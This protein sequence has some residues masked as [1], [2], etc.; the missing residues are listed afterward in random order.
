MSDELYTVDRVADRLQL[1]PKTVLRF[2]REGR[3]R[4][5]RVGKGYRILRSDLEA[6]AGVAVDSTT[7]PLRARVTS[8]V[9]L[10]EVPAELSRR[11]STALQAALMTRPDRSN[12]IQLDTAYDSEARHLKVVI[13]A[14][15]ADA[16]AL[17]RTLEVFL[18]AFK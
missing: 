4:A 7:P 5:T 2:I 3:L 9:D 10:P 16:A 14:A 13:V 8:I 18:D 6:F 12:P 11:L 15:P 1:H 17:L